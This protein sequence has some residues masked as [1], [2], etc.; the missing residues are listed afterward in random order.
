V[1]SDEGGDA[2]TAKLHLTLDT[3]IFEVHLSVNGAIY[4]TSEIIGNAY[5]T[6]STYIFEKN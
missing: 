4:K 6:Q 2:G 3:E 5:V 1:A